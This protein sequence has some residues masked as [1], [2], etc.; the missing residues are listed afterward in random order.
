MTTGIAVPDA[1]PL[2]SLYQID[3]LELLH[4]LFE[5]VVV[6]PAVEREVWPSLGELPLWAERRSVLPPLGFADHLHSGEREAIALAVQLA[7]DLVLMDDLQGR[8]VATALGLTVVGSLGLLVR[9]KRVMLIREVRPLMDAMIA[10]GLYASNAVYRQ[11][12]T[13]AGESE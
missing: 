9:A 10:S 5:R 11:I 6:P 4:G 3:R 8:H 12:L 1:S 13:I 7:A 2:I